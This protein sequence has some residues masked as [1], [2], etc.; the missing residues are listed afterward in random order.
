MRRGLF[1]FR[2]RGVQEAKVLKASNVRTICHR[3]I[4]SALAADLGVIIIT[5]NR[6]SAVILA[7]IAGLA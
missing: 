3:E 4:H 5:L 2:E 6:K 1:D 7:R